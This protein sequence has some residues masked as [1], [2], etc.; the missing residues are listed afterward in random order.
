MSYYIFLKR[1]TQMNETLIKL[2]V[3]KSSPYTRKMNAYLRYKR[4]PHSVIWGEASDV[5]KK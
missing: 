4:I 1:L 5:L 3:N 2:K